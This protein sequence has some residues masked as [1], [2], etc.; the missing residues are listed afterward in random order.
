MKEATPELG[1]SEA[2]HRKAGETR[3]QSPRG[4]R[5]GPARAGG[6]HARQ[7][8]QRELRPQGNTD[9]MR[10]INVSFKTAEIP[11]A[12]RDTGRAGAS[13]GCGRGR[14][15][16]WGPPA[17]RVN[18]RAPFQASLPGEMEADVQSLCAQMFLQPDSE[19]PVMV[20]IRIFKVSCVEIL[21]P[22]WRHDG[23]VLEP[24]V[25]KA[26]WEEVGHWG[27]SI[28]SLRQNESFRL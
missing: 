17:S 9:V 2:D 22:S 3:E 1:K 5:P 16:A 25:C 27:R 19:H 28:L 21:I 23:E 26:S 10:S 6:A 15:T 13:P 20:G 7:S 24:L 18:L 8:Q 11:S 4:R 12:G 14:G